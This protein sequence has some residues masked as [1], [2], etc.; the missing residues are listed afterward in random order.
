MGKNIFPIF[1][2]E[3]KLENSGF[4][5]YNALKRKRLL[6]AGLYFPKANAL[7]LALK[8]PFD[9]GLMAQNNKYG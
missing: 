8:E 3:Y 4:Q 5:G 1:K 9:V 6:R 2:L 7:L